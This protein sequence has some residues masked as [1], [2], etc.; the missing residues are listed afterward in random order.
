MQ[1]ELRPTTALVPSARSRDALILGLSAT[2]AHPF[3]ADEAADKRSDNKYK[4]P[5]Q[6]ADILT[7]QAQP[8]RRDIKLSMLETT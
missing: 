7:Q 3:P 1:V 4:F 2:F 5:A 6:P 8:T